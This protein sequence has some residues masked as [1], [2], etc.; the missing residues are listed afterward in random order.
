MENKDYVEKMQKEILLKMV[1][2]DNLRK[3]N[4]EHELQEGSLEKQINELHKVLEEREE[5][6]LKNKDRE[7]ELEEEVKEVL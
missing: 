7:K 6:V 1:E 5:S 2:I 4:A 3:E